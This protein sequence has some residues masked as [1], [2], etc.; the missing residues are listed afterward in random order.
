MIAESSASAFHLEDRTCQECGTAY[1]IEQFYQS[2][3]SYFDPPENYRDGCEKY[4]LSC[5]L[6]V[7]PNDFPPDPEQGTLETVWI[8][9]TSQ[10][11]SP[12]AGR[13]G[14]NP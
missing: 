8:P 12:A 10:G 6:C 3:E 1:T 4:C 2:C 11:Y 13:S 5:W 9:R 14:T 7:G